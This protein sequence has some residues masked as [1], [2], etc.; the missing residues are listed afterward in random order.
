MRSINSTLI[1]GGDSFVAKNLSFGNKVTRAECDLTNLNQILKTLKKV[2]PL[3]VINCAAAHGSAKSMSFNHS[4]FLTHN[5]IIDSNILRACHE[6]DIQNVVLLSSISAFPNKENSKLS[7][8]NLYDGPVNEFNFGYNLS[9][10]LSYDLCKTY[11]LDFNRNYK[12]L[13][14]GNLYGKYGKF[15]LDSNVLHSV[16][17]QI[18]QAK[19]EGKDLK[20]Y[21]TGEDQRAFTFVEDLNLFIE[22]FIT[23]ENIESA[24]FSSNEVYSIREITKKVAV[25]MNFEG[26]IMFTGETFNNQ[27]RKVISAEYLMEKIPNLK[28]TPLDYGLRKVVDWYVNPLNHQIDF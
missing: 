7:E 8:I 11:A 5:F 12:V 15:A 6:L 20:L 26:K 2:N 22:T 1:F 14:L 21:G 19:L 16:I 17:F 10:R 9:K 18:W 27:K 3:F 13:F 24:I 23:K 4:Y 25:L 28:L